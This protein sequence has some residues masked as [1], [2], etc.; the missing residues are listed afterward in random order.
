MCGFQNKIYP[1]KELKINVHSQTKIER[2][3]LWQVKEFRI[4]WEKNQKKKNLE[5]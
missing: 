5:D 2:R 4:G 1:K 3:E